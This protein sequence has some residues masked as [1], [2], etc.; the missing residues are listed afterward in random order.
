M[1]MGRIGAARE[2]DITAKAIARP[3]KRMRRVFS[4]VRL[5]RVVLCTV[6][7]TETGLVV[8][9]GYDRSLLCY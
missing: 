3:K 6:T 9:E 1:E 7:E 5:L 2:S 8:C 4:L